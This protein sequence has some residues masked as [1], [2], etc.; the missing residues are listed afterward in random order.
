M[1]SVPSAKALRRHVLTVSGAMYDQTLMDKT[2]ERLTLMP[3]TAVAKR[4]A[5][6]RGNEI[7]VS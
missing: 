5:A 1:A 3:W 4:C 6:L 2:V 7:N